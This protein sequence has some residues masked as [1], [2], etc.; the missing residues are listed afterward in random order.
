M[1]SFGTDWCTSVKIKMIVKIGRTTFSARRDGLEN[2]GVVKRRL[3][4][5]VLGVGKM[6]SDGSSLLRSGCDAWST[7]CSGMDCGW[8]DMPVMNLQE[9]LIE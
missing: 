8:L 2:D 9:G 6:S 5:E 1:S 3:G 4:V 7:G